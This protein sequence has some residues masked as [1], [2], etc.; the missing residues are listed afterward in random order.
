[1]SRQGS[2]GYLSAIP[3]A[4]KLALEVSSD[5]DQVVRAVACRAVLCRHNLPVS[6]AT[7]RDLVPVW[8]ESPRD[9]RWIWAGYD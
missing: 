2:R 5:E 3:G 1:M 6:A 9:K 7:Y 4:R 8:P